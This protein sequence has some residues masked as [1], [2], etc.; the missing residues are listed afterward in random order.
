MRVFTQITREIHIIDNLKANILIDSNILISK[1]IIINF[2]IQLIIIKSYRSITISIN[3]RARLDSIK[4]IIKTSSRIILLSYF[5][6]LI[7]I[8][9]ADELS[10]NRDLL[11]KS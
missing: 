6:T 4:R 3:S 5:V 10:Q 8:I 9:Y 2:D 11:F 7:S 1:R